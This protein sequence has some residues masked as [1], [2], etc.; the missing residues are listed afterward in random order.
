MHAELR[1]TDGIGVGRKRVAR[2]MA[3]A[4][5]EN[6]PVPRK[7]RTTVRVAGV[8]VAPDL[9][10]RNFS[11]TAPD[12][13][14]C[15]DITYLATWEGTLYLASVIDCYSRLIVGW[16]MLSHMR[17]ELIESA[18]AM[19]VGRRRPGPGLIH[20][21]DHGS[22]RWGTA[23]SPE[24]ISQRLRLDFPDDESMRVSHEAIYQSLFI[25]GRGALRRELSACRRTGRALR[26]PRARAHSRRKGFITQEVM[27]SQRPAEAEDHAVPGHWESDLILGLGSSAIGTLVERSSRFT[28]LL[29]LPPMA[30]SGPGCTTVRP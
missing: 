3:G 9:V 7:T 20:H 1:L 10:D 11:P 4:G 27:I 5:L 13:L 21:S 23:W 17:L 28:M 15:A 29:H 8:R 16:A 2:L 25:Q 30:G 12:R 24:Q 19:A 18:L 22:R 26:A 6:I 14:W